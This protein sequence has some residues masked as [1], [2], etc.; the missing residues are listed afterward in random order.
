[1]N[2]EEFIESRKSKPAPTETEIRAMAQKYN[3][4]ESWVQDEL[5]TAK[6]G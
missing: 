3:M 4:S 5:K 2:I 1:M 6:K